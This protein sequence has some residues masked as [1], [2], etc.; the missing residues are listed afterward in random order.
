MKISY[1]IH[2][3]LKRKCK[4]SNFLF[5]QVENWQKQEADRKSMSESAR[6]LSDLHKILDEV[7]SFVNS[8]VLEKLASYEREIES[9]KNSLTELTKKKDEIEQTIS[10]LKEDIASQEIGKRELLDNMT[11]RKIKEM[12]ETLKEQYRKLNEKLKNMDYKEMM[13]KWEQ[14][15]NEK[16]T[17]LQQVSNIL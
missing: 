13:K 2:E 1:V 6:R 3:Y 4:H 10:E 15:E 12:L 9:Y 7:N 5:L 11:L 16:Q 17:L 8:K 14:L